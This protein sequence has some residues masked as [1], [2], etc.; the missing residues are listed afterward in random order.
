MNPQPTYNP[1]HT[2]MLL[3]IARTILLSLLHHVRHTRQVNVNS[4]SLIIPCSTTTFTQPYRCA[5]RSAL[6]RRAFIRV[7]RNQGVKDAREPYAPSQRSLCNEREKNELR[8]RLHPAHSVFSAAA[9]VFLFFLSCL[10]YVST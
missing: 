10:M 4:Q 3:R 5:V 8:R 6:A 9:T 7:R 1:L 2:H